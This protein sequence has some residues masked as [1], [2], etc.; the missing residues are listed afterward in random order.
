M[1]IYLLARLRRLKNMPAATLEFALDKFVVEC[2]AL[3]KTISTSR[4]EIQ[5]VLRVLDRLRYF[6]SVMITPGLNSDVDSICT[7]KLH[8][9][10]ST[11]GVGLT[12]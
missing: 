1:A 12:R 9:R 7:G 4:E 5:G 2:V 3:T 6:L 11:V 10:S 8:L